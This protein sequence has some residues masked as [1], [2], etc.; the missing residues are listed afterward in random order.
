MLCGPS[1]PRYVRHM[2][3]GPRMLPIC[4]HSMPHIGLMA[5]VCCAY[6]PSSL[7]ILGIW[8]LA[9]LYDASSACQHASYWAY[10]M[11]MCTSAHKHHQIHSAS[12]DSVVIAGLAPASVCATCRCVHL[13]AYRP[14]ISYRVIRQRRDS[15][16]C[17]TA[18]FSALLVIRCIASVAASS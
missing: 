15:Q 7:C 3:L 4:Q 6:G 16:A 13:S 14:H 17:L 2:G 5:C 8:V 1:S 12:K 10:S 18:C 9:L 11:C